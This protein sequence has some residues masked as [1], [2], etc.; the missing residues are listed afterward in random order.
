MIPLYILKKF[1]T[2]FVSIYN[3]SISI[4]SLIYL[5]TTIF[6]N[7]FVPKWGNYFANKSFNKIKDS[8]K[9]I[10]RWNFFIASI[11]FITFLIS[12]N[13]I[14]ILFYTNKYIDIHQYLYI[15]LF[16]FLFSALTG[17]SEGIIKVYG[18]TKYIFI[19]RCISSLFSI[20]LILTLPVYF[21]K[22]GIILTYFIS[23]IIGNLLYT[24]FIYFKYNF[25][26]FD[27]SYF[28]IL[29]IFILNL[30][31]STSFL[32]IENIVS[33]NLAHV[34]IIFF[35]ICIIQLALFLIFRFF[36]NSED[37]DLLY[38]LYKR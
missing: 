37:K 30:F 7:I 31:I 1:D 29:L 16:T 34:L 23:S 32:S 18:D 26:P 11:L 9:F 19:S 38:N 2:E 5:T 4:A 12:Q 22:L 25:H 13:Q 10:T 17:P 20:I 21:N 8:Y 35:I 28:I 33:N 3:L 27:K 24:F 15:F 36:M 14:I 6:E